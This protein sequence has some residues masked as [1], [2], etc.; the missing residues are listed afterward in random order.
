M[1]ISSKLMA[2]V[3]TAA[4]AAGLAACGD[5]DDSDSEATAATSSGSSS[6]LVAVA[7]VSGT[8]VLADVDGRTLYTAAVESDGIL[9]VDACVSFWAPIEA[10]SAEADEAASDLGLDLG[11]VERPEGESQ[12]T[13]D[14]LPLYTFTDEG[15]GELT[16]DGFV[17]D[18]QGTQFEWEAASAAGASDVAETE[19]AEPDSSSGPLGY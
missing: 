11:V 18:F 16:G 7:D 14:G 10:S 4:L 9:C 1:R 8:E 6:E 13:L 17:D 3:A 12:L 2:A 5:D 19:P 15:P